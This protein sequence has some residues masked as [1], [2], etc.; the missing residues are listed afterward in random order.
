MR[1]MD[2]ISL[3]PHQGARE[4]A[5]LIR[6]RLLNKGVLHFRK[7]KLEGQIVVHEPY[8]FILAQVSHPTRH[9]DRRSRFHLNPRIIMTNKQEQLLG[10]CDQRADAAA[11]DHFWT[12][13]GNDLTLE[14]CDCSPQDLRRD[15][16]T[17]PLA[18]GPLHS[19]EVT[20]T[21]ECPKP[22]AFDRS[23]NVWHGFQVRGR[24][25]YLRRKTTHCLPVSTEKDPLFP[26]KLCPHGSE[27]EKRRGLSALGPPGHEH[28]YAMMD[29]S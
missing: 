24:E 11:K 22:R 25:F 17:D 4:N 28:A 5:V 14:C 26:N 16:A 18:Q 20:K 15:R 7:R 3:H 2:R 12:H 9:F 13:L 29:K 27:S 23:T 6:R 10:L 1:M 8:L 19:A 21:F